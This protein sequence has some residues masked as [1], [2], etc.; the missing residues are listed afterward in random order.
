M[1]IKHIAWRDAS[2]LKDTGQNEW[3]ELDEAIEK[4]EELWKDHCETVGWI[5]YENKDFI[6]IATTKSN[7]I[8]ADLTMIPK[9]LIVQSKDPK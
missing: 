1:R 3:F 9:S 8:Y 4:A 2:G 7:T 6:I 5:I